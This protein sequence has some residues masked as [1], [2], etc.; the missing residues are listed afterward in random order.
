MRPNRTGWAAAAVLTI[1]AVLGSSACAASGAKGGRKAAAGGEDDPQYQVEKGMIALRYGLTEE[2]VRYGNLAIALD[3]DSFNAHSLLGSAYY[4]LGQ[5]ER[6]VEAYEKAA[7]LKPDVAEVHR[8]LGL[9]YFEIKETEKAEAAFRK[10]FEMSGDPEAVFYLARAA[11]NRQEYEAAL[12]WVLKAIQK[13]GKNAGFY[14]LKGAVLNQMGRYAEAIGSFQ[15]GLILAPE[16][17]NIQVNLGTAYVNNEEPEKAK[18]VL[19]RVLPKIQDA[20]M[21]A[22]VEN[23]L[24]S[25]RGGQISTY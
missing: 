19:E 22:R 2:A 5:F 9:A 12:D 21:K 11:Y 15:A 23:I 17:V 10:A 16:D 14:N 25:L 13:D 18:A 8:N 24:K 7:A 1:A 6:S 4:T 20:V 3:P